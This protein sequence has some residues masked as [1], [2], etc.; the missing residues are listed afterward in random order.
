MVEDIE[1]A[2]KSFGTDVSTLKVRTTRKS[3]KVVADD[4][5]EILK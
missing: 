1:I 5:V 4:F 3:P 2:E